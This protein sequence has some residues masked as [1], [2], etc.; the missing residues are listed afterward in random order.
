MTAARRAPTVTS[1][2]LSEPLHRILPIRPHHAGIG[3]KHKFHSADS[4]STDPSAR[5]QSAT[6][7]RRTYSFTSS[8]SSTGGGT[9]GV[10]YVVYVGVVGVQTACTAPTDSR[11]FGC[12]PIRRNDQPCPRNFLI[13]SLRG[14]RV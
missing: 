7:V 14:S 6:N 11:T 4:R 10:V 2:A 1:T 9:A 5:I 13:R 12:A 8:S 3:R